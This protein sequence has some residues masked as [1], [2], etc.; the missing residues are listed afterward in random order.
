[1]QAVRLD[2]PEPTGIAGHLT[3]L[4]SLSIRT[5]GQAVLGEQQAA[6]AAQNQGLRSLALLCDRYPERKLQPD[7]LRQVLTSCTRLTQLD[8]HNLVVDDQG[9]EVLLT[10]GT[11]ITDLTLGKSRLTASKADRACSWRRLVLGYGTLQEY[12]YLPLKSVQLLQEVRRRP[13]PVVE[14][15][16]PFDVPAAQPPDLLHQATTNLASCPAW[17]KAPPSQLTLSGY[18]QGLT[19]AQRVQLLDALAP[20]AGRHVRELRLGV[21]VQLGGAEVEALAASFAGS[22]KSLHLDSATLLD[23]FWTP[24]AQRFPNLQQL[25]LGRDIK[26]GV[27]SLAMYLATFSCSASHVLDVSIECFGEEEAEQLQSSADAWSLE[28]IRLH[29]EPDTEVDDG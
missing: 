19:S 2:E 20:V 6:V 25:C 12:A 5:D 26:A 24:L 8:L 29:V 17:A 7:L 27:T 13:A 10:H 22:L 23:S 28:N 4:T 11:S 3:G 18:P 16:L 14:L 1:L 9:L 21:R 15:D